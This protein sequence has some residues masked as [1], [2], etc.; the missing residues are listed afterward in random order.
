MKDLVSTEFSAE[1]HSQ[2]VEKKAFLEFSLGGESYA[3]EL[4]KVKEVI[5]TPELTPLPMVPS[6]VSGIMNMRGLILNV[7]DLRTKMNIRPAGDPN[8][9]V[10]IVFDLEGT[11][12]GAKV[13]GIQKVINIF[14]KDIKPVPDSDQSPVSLLGILHQENKLSM[15]IDP[16]VLLNEHY[17]QKKAA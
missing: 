13:D 4:L 2:S 11:V 9:N 6:Y 12:V 5:M 10:V 3:V 15:W 14:P 16:K 1:N 8:Q 17:S 7:I